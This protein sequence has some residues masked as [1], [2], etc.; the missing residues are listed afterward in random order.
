MSS[1]T[2]KATRFGTDDVKEIAV[3][4]NW[5]GGAFLVRHHHDLK[6]DDDVPIA[7]L[8][9]VSK[10]SDRIFRL[11]ALDAPL[12]S[13]MHLLRVTTNGLECTVIAQK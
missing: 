1:A 7:A 9:I 5:G 11:Q 12:F 10:L 3:I 13:T 2:R 8:G 6:S 4:I